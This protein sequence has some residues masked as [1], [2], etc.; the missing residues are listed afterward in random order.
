MGQVICDCISWRVKNITLGGQ[1]YLHA[2]W[3]RQHPSNHCF[4]TSSSLRYG[5]ITK[6]FIGFLQCLVVRRLSAMLRGGRRWNCSGDSREYRMSSERR[7]YTM[8]AWKVHQ[9]ASLG[10]FDRFECSR[11]MFVTGEGDDRGKP[12]WNCNHFLEISGGHRPQRRIM[13][14]SADNIH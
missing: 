7:G 3:I 4:C 8:T 10:N 2:A 1:I 13:V 14:H 12:V 6:S 5:K 9:N 11:N